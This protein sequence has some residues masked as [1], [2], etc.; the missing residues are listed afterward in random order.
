MKH[1]QSWERRRR[2]G[3]EEESELE[4]YHLAAADPRELLAVVTQDLSADSAH[5]TLLRRGVPA[6]RARR[7]KHA[8]FCSI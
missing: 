8:S 4:F 3:R 6:P 2:D 1:S 7:P 5:V